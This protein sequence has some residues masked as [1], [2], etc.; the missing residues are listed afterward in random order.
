MRYKILIMKS[1]LN[2]LTFHR[3]HLNKKLYS[4]LDNLER[5]LES[6]NEEINQLSRNLESGRDSNNRLFEEKC[7]LEKNVKFNFRSLFQVSE[8]S[9]LKSRNRIQI[10]RLN[11]NVEKLTQINTEHEITI[12]NINHDKNN[13]QKRLDDVIF[14][15]S[16]NIS[17]LKAKED[18][19]N[20]T[21]NQLDETT[22]NLNKQQVKFI[23]KISFKTQSQREITKD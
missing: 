9:D 5:V 21:K 17:K 18:A 22:K 8:L 14:E 12:K 23:L 6:K 13:L 3:L 7:S 11:E 10:D 15:N 19:L 4:E 1:N 20:Y 2:K 16:S